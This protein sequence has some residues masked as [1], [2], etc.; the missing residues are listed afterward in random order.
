M[1]LSPGAGIASAAGKSALHASAGY[2][3][4]R[5]C[6]CRK[7]FSAGVPGAKPPA[8]YTLG[9]PL[10]RR[11]RGLGGWGQESKL[12]AGRQATSK[13]SHPPGAWFV[14]LPQCRP[15]SAPGHLHGMVCTCRPGS[16]RGCKGRSHLHKITLV[17][18]FPGGE[19]GWGDRAESKL[20]AGAAGDKECKPPRWVPERQGQAGDKQGKTPAGHRGGAVTRRPKRQAP[21]PAGQKT[22]P[23]SG[24]PCGA[25]PQGGENA[26]S[27]G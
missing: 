6:K 1:V 12:K 26:E 3:R 15:G 10:P 17:S 5:L 9:R 22:P 2:S 8:K 27:S 14:P 21:L 19:G 23:H 7:R 24:T 20:K 18:P 13:A 16:A 25:P 4:G 11:G